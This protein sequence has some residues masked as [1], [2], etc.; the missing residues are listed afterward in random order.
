MPKSS[1]PLV[2]QPSIYSIILFSI[3]LYYLLR[4]QSLL[5]NLSEKLSHFIIIF[6]INHRKV[7]HSLL[8]Y[9]RTVLPYKGSITYIF[10]A[11]FSQHLLFLIYV[12]THHSS[13]LVLPINF[14]SFSMS[15]SV[16]SFLHICCLLYT[17]PSPRDQRGSRMPSSA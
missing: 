12:S 5:Y 9:F 15:S 16:L 13:I 4:T 8:I 10:L 7:D 11:A 3:I 6:N 17:S 1:L 2:H 14:R